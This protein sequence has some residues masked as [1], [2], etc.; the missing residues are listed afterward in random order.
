MRSVRCPPDMP[1]PPASTPS[2]A[3]HPAR[4]T[5]TTP[6]VPIF[7]QDARDVTMFAPR[8]M[9]TRTSWTTKNQELEPLLLWDLRIQTVPRSMEDLSVVLIMENAPD[10][11]AQIPRVNSVFSLMVM[12]T[13]QRM[14]RSQSY[15]IEY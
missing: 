13:V 3:D 10:T 1:Q 15:L 4:S 6:N 7:P 14:R 9:E 12:K 2:A 8:E 5:P 11:Q